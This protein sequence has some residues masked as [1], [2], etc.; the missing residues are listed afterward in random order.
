MAPRVHR[1]TI[2]VRY[3]E[4]DAQGVVYHSN[5]L[6]YFEVARTSALKAW[7]LVYREVEAQGVFV[8][9]VEAQVRYLGPARYDDELS[10]EAEI[11]EVRSRSFTVG[12]RIFLG[13]KLLA[14]GKT[15]HVTL[16]REGKPVPLPEAL[17]QALGAADAPA[18]AATSA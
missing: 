12:Y 18:E 13:D 9:V 11:L 15:A 5:H 16:N 10:V 1:T 6:V 17:R 2:H 8:A 4:T 7:G 3:A 14:E